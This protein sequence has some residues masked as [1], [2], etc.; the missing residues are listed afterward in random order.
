MSD[1][2]IELMIVAIVA[3]L[4][5]Y[6]IKLLIASSNTPTRTTRRGAIKPSH[7]G[8]GFIPPVGSWVG[9]S[10]GGG[11]SHGGGTAH[12]GGFDVGGF[13]GGDCGGGGGGC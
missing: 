4:T 8:G 2:M 3:G 10:D 13:G 9:G 6:Y 5:A 1:E 7:S 11:G 12:G